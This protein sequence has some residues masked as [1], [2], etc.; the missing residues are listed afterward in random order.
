M[1]SCTACGKHYKG[2]YLK[3]PFCG[4]WNT[5]VHN[6]HLG[7]QLCKVKSVIVPRVETGPW[8]YMW[9]T[10]WKDGR[11]GPVENPLLSLVVLLEREKVLSY[12]QWL[13]PQVF[14]LEKIPFIIPAKSPTNRLRDEQND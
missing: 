5:G 3:C 14:P 12:L 4:T 1:N 13:L 8:D 2:D 6:E 10:N 9:G 7:I 11:K